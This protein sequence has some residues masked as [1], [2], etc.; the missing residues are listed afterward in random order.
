[1]THY[2]SDDEY[3]PNISDIAEKLFHREIQQ[4]TRKQIALERQLEVNFADAENIQMHLREVS[5]RELPAA[6][7][8]NGFDT[9]LFSDGVRVSLVMS[10]EKKVRSIVSGPKDQWLQ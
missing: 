5:L 10:G 1:M 4:L 2:R 6:L 8:K 9:Y 3:L 7:E